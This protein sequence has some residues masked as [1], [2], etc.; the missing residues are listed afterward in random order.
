[1]IGILRSCLPGWA[2]RH[3]IVRRNWTG[4]RHRYN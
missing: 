3:G 2:G 1:M 4:A